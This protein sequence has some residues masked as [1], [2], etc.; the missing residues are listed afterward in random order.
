MIKHNSYYSGSSFSLVFLFCLTIFISNHSQ[1]QNKVKVPPDDD[2]ALTFSKGDQKRINRAKEKLETIEKSVLAEA[3][4]LYNPLLITTDSTTEANKDAFFKMKGVSDEFRDANEVIFSIQQEYILEF[5]KKK[6]KGLYIK[7]LVRT[8]TME[9]EANLYYRSAQEKRQL[10]LTT[11]DYNKGYQILVSAINLEF[12]AIKKQGRALRKYQDWPV[13]YSYA[14]EE[15]V[16]P[17]EIPNNMQHFAAVDTIKK[18]ADTIKKEDEVP[19]FSPIIFKVQ[20]AAHTI[21]LSENYL[22]T[23]Y[24]GTHKIDMIYE[25][26]WYK[27]SI[28]AYSS[29]QQASELMRETNVPRAFVVAYQAGKKIK[30]KEALKQSK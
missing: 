2:L 1:A 25:D 14:W 20:I 27:Y 4:A 5:W 16:K 21:P 13:A 17:D 26:G 30:I 24:P 3:E 7:E 19:L 18:T 15:V 23:L 29:F 22:K 12:T 11:S 6:I 9:R 8:K 10:V 28:G